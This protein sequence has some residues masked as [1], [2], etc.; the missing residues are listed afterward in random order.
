MGTEHR[1]DENQ[2]GQARLVL[3]GVHL[4]EQAAV[5]ETDDDPAVDVQGQTEGVEVVGRLLDG[6]AVPWRV[7]GQAAA[8]VVVVDHPGELGG[9]GEGGVEGVV[10]A[11][12]AAVQQHHREA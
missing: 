7:G 11:A 8:A 3:R 5:R 10:G 2:A 1:G 6:V 4:G 12:G 9:A